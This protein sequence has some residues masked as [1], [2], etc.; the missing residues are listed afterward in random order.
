MEVYNCDNGNEV[1]VHQ[2]GFQEGLFYGKRLTRLDQYSL[3]P[4]RMLQVNAY[5]IFVPAGMSRV[6]III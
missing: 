6:R 5:L 4:G 1:K 3:T 2:M